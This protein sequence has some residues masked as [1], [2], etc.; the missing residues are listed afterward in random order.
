MRRQSNDKYIGSSMSLCDMLCSRQASTNP[1]HSIPLPN[2]TNPCTDTFH[3]ISG[4]IEGFWG[5]EGFDEETVVCAFEIR[6]LGFSVIF[7]FL[8]YIT[9]SKR[10]KAELH[11]TMNHF[12]EDKSW[13]DDT[14]QDRQEKR[15][16]YVP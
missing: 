6:S 1:Q 8:K 12:V 16:W 9:S 13:G 2:K 14:N 15:C 7:F 3:C 11:R 10:R 4:S 5:Q